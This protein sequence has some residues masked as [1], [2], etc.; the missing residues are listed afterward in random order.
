MVDDIDTTVANRKR[1]TG[2]S[3]RPLSCLESA[4]SNQLT[5]QDNYGLLYCA[6]TV[7]QLKHICN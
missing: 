1:R 3:S 2:S 5:V 6:E 4:I 7:K